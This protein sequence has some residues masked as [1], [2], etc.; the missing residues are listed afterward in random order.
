[1]KSQLPCFPTQ[2]STRASRILRLLFLGCAITLYSTAQW[3]R[4]DQNW[5][6]DNPIGNFS[7]ADNW[8]GN[9]V[10]G[11]SG[12]GFNNGSLHFSFRNNPSQTSIFYDFAGFA[13]T[14]DIFWDST[15]SVGLT[16]DGN[17]QGL[18][19]NQRLENDSSFTQTIGSGMNL[20]GAKN[21]ATQ[22]ELNP[23]NG[24]LVLNGN[25]FNDNAKPYHVFGNNGKSVTINVTL[26]TG[27][28]PSAVSFTVDQNSTAI[29]TASQNYTGATTINAGSV[30]IGN[31]GTTGALSTS[32]AITDNANLT[33][34]RSDNI[35]QGTDFSGSAISGTGA[36]TKL[37]GG[38]VTLNT[39][40]TYQGGTSVQAGTLLVTNTSGSGTG[41]GAVTVTNSGTTLAGGTTNGV[42][43]I[44]GA[45]NINSSGANLSPGT[46]GNGVG[47]TA[48]LKTGALTLASTSNFKVDLNSTTAGSGYDQVNVT[49][50]VSVTGSNLVITAANSG[51]AVGNKF[52]IALNDGTDPVTGPFAQGATVT[53]SN[54]GDIFAINYLDNGDGG[55]IGNDISLTLVAVPE[56][57]TWM[58]A[59]LT[60]GALAY[61]LRRRRSRRQA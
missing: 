53:A 44:S 56:P 31:G 49:G 25:I 29:F 42:G 43:G 28:N 16:L 10:G 15:F 4:A 32:S 13:D 7:F 11:L 57:S 47:T 39:A 61:G 24:N 14:N 23:V 50:T 2:F 52:F 58:A 46:T 37:G 9:T 5:D 21:G 60:L 54:N 45:V 1:M 48:I 8:F 20:S 3:V 34:N 19:F 18:N 33:F 17:G 36:V 30:Q 12:F 51:L 59:A 40:N 6:G 26:G 41:T 27:S 35:S 22:I 55:T 38:I